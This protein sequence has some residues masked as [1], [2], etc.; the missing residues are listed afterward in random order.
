MRAVGENPGAAEAAAVLDRREVARVMALPGFDQAVRQAVSCWLPRDM[1][2]TGDI[3]LLRDV[4]RVVGAILTFYL[5]GEP[6]GLTRPRLEALLTATGVSS[7]GRAASIL[8]YLR[9]IGYIEPDQGAGEGAGVRRFAPTAKLIAAYFGRIR[10]EL[11][12]AAALDADIARLCA[13][14]DEP[15]LARAWAHR[16]GEQVVAVLEHLSAPEISLDVFSHRNGGMMI[17]AGLLQNAETSSGDTFPAAGRVRFS[18]SRLA[19]LSASS[20]AHV[21]HQLQAAEKLGLLADLAEGEATITPTLAYNVRFFC[22]GNVR[23]FAWN[24]RRVL[25]EA[26]PQVC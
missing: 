17:L 25:A 21:R 4:G 9:F 18:V 7:R 24:A 15:G 3:G 16:H 13:R 12:W 20:R 6:G 19:R 14:F 2:D 23:M 8:I 10:R 1:A 11:A 26:G 22:A 5:D